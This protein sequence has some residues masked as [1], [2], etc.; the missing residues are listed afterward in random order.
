MAILI[1]LAIYPSI[2]ILFWLLGDWL[3]TIPLLL[4]TLILTGILVPLMVFVLLPLLTR[5]FRT[6]LARK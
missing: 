3:M 2:N 1:W 5:W 4:R 6:W